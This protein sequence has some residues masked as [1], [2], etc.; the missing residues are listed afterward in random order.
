MLVTGERHQGL[1]RL[2]TRVIGLA[3]EEHACLANSVDSSQVWHERLGH[4][5]KQYV[6]KY[7]KTNN[8]VFA[9]DSQLCEGCVLGKQHRLSF[10]RRVKRAQAAEELIHADVCG[11]MQEDSFQGFSIFLSSKTTTLS[12]EVFIF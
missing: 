11:P 12:I 2:N 5:N 10:G 8:F 6:E 9:K 3:S 1:Y 4:Q 7:L